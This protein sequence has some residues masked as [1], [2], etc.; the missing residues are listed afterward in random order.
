MLANTV[1]SEVGFDA[2]LLPVPTDKAVR[3][4]DH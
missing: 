4:L 2:I 3:R 1:R